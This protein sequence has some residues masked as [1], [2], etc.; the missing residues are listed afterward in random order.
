MFVIHRYDEVF[1]LAAGL[2]K[3]TPFLRINLSYL[4]SPEQHIPLLSL[5]LVPDTQQLL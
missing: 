1:N 2:S 4:V 5:R 3:Y